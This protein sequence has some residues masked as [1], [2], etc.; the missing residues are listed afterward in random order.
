MVS[1]RAVSQPTCECGRAVRL[2]VAKARI[3]ESVTI[4][5]QW[6]RCSTSRHDA[7]P[8]AVCYFRL[9]GRVLRHSSL[10]LYHRTS[11]AWS[12][13]ECFKRAEPVPCFFSRRTLPRSHGD[14]TAGMCHVYA[15]LLGSARLHV[16]QRHLSCISLCRM[17]Q[18]V[19]YPEPPCSALLLP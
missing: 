19:L 18:Q 16:L 17:K 5:W 8:T 11:L 15:V 1:R 9:P 3:A 2:K 4:A 12:A 7:K 13:G 6:N 14:T 10:E